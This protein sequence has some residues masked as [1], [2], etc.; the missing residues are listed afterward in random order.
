MSIT[1]RRREV[2]RWNL[3]DMEHPQFVT[4]D[5]PVHPV[6]IYTYGT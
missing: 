3:A 4:H 6:V 2:R 1:A 5:A